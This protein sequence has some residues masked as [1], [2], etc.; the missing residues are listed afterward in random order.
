MIGKKEYINNLT[1][2]IK[3]I[4]VELE[5]DNKKKKISSNQDFN[6]KIEEIKHYDKKNFYL[7]EKKEK[8]ISIL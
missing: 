1:K 3:D 8:I 6:N 5:N 2:I 4:I 7:I